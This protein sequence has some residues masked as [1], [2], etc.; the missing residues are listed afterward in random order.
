MDRHGEAVG[1]EIVD[2]GLADPARAAGHEG[3]FEGLLQRGSLSA[4]LF[5]LTSSRYR[6]LCRGLNGRLQKL[7]PD[8]NRKMRERVISITISI[9]WSFPRLW[10]TNTLLSLSNIQLS[11]CS[12]HRDST[13]WLLEI[14]N[15]YSNLIS[16]GRVKNEFDDVREAEGQ[17]PDATDMCHQRRI[18]CVHSSPPSWLPQ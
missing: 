16:T 3:R 9:V 7:Y 6:E 18:V 13:F 11:T 14:L 1:G 10:L 5:G 15:L 12:C 2:D 8:V 17:K 4:I